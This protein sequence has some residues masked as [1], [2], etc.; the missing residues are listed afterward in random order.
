MLFYSNDHRAQQ[1][2]LPLRLRYAAIFLT[3]A[4]Y[5]YIPEERIHPALQPASVRAMAGLGVP[6]AYS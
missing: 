4:L 1:V 5:R 3:L 2:Y 6:A